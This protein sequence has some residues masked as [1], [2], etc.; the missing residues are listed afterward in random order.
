MKEVGARNNGGA[1]D[2]DQLS[3]AEETSQ[4]MNHLIWTLNDGDSLSR[5]IEGKNKIDVF[6][7]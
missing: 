6:F 4:K 3:L 1:Q 7:C 5:Q 2:S